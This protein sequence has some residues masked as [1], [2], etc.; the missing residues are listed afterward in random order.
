[1]MNIIGQITE[2]QITEVLITDRPFNSFTIQFEKVMKL[3]S[4]IRPPFCFMILIPI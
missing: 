1:M 4:K 3:D 2:G